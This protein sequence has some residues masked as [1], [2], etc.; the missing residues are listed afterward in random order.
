[1]SKF[2][3]NEELFLNYVGVKD[4]LR[5][6]RNGLRNVKYSDIQLLGLDSSK[7][8]DF[9]NYIVAEYGVFIFRDEA[10]YYSDNAVVQ[11]INFIKDIPLLSDE[12]FKRYFYEYKHG[13]KDALDMLVVSNLRLVPY[14][15]RSF[16]D[17]RLPFADLIS[18]G[19][20]GLYD[21]LRKYDPSK[22]RF[23]T[24]AYE[25]ISQKMNRAVASE[26]RNVRFAYGAY[27]KFTKYS[28]FLI[29]Y[30][31]TNGCYPSDSVIMDEIGITHD[32]LEK[33]K[34]FYH[35]TISFNTP[36]VDADESY[37]EDFICDK[38]EFSVPD[39]IYKKELA[40][41][42]DNI[43]KG[44]SPRKEKIIKMRFALDAGEHK[45][46]RE[47]SEELGITKEGVRASQNRILKKLK[48]SVEVKRLHPDYDREESSYEISCRKSENSKFI[49]SVVSSVY[50]L[51]DI[52]AEEICIIKALFSSGGPISVNKVMELEELSPYD[53]EVKL[54][55]INDAIDKY[56]TLYKKG[57]KKYVRK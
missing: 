55:L 57:V 7:E 30:Y 39:I 51:D 3:I 25:W 24:Y 28:S 23:S 14:V 44:Y 11:Y 13:S 6:I 53:D 18:A 46:L 43:L 19:N 38:D 32:T 4:L 8:N 26:S 17:G 54:K 1:M 48:N 27:Y 50:N 22:G 2:E 15:A 40:S 56:L 35:D 12:E 5:R 31:S 36:I 41:S 29:K 42:F 10:D 16:Y 49:D 33:F 9:I 52:T 20:L 34:M 21:A 45:T 37:L 47:V